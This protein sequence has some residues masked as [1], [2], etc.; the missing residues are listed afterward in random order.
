MVFKPLSAVPS[1]ANSSQTVDP[2]GPS[3]KSPHAI[4]AE[5]RR[6]ALLSF[7][8][9]LHR[10]LASTMPTALTTLP[11]RHRTANCAVQHSTVGSA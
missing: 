9:P 3:G 10:W 7:P 6:V 5:R 2:G 11:N 1:E 4:E 8:A